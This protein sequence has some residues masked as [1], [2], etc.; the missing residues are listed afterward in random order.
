MPLKMWI[1]AALALATI[2]ASSGA[3]LASTV[4]GPQLERARTALAEAEA[5]HAAR[6]RAHAEAASMKLLAAAERG[7][8]LTR[9]L[10]AARRAA[11]TL[12]KERDDAIAL[13]TTGRECFDAAALRVLDGAPGLRVDL[14]E[15]ARG[16]DG[17]DADLTATDTDIGR[18]ALAAGERYDECR[19]RYQALIDWHLQAAP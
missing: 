13:G 19:R 16:A 12:K 15:T 10:W 9:D 4:K 14:P 6:E 5:R 8:A 11:E 7:D 17:A 18:W 3:W 1:A 2:S